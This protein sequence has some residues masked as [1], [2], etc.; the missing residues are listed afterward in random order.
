MLH[1][2]T[3]H[4]RSFSRG[5]PHSIPFDHLDIC[6]FNSTRTP[7]PSCQVD[8][9][10]PPDH[11]HITSSPSSNM[12]HT[13][14][15]VPQSSHPGTHIKTTTLLSFV[16]DHYPIAYS[17]NT[18]QHTQ[19][20]VYSTLDHCSILAQ[21]VRSA[22]PNFRAQTVNTRGTSRRNRTQR[23][24][25]RNALQ[26]QAEQDIIQRD[27][28][29][30]QRLGHVDADHDPGPA[31]WEDID[32]APHAEYEPHISSNAGQ[33]LDEYIAD[34]PSAAHASYHR[35]R[36]YAEKRD[37][38]HKQWVQLEQKTV[39]AYLLCQK[40]TA[41]WTFI[42][43]GIGWDGYTPISCSCVPSDIQS[44][45]VA[46]YDIISRQTP[47]LLP[48]CKCTPDVIRLIHYGFFASSPNKPR[49]A[50]SIRL[51]QFHH[52]L[53]ESAVIS[54]SAFV[55]GLSAF[56]DTRKAEA[57]YARGGKY[58]KRNLRVPFS[59]SVDLYARILV[60]RRK[61]LDVGLQLIRT[62]LW[63]AKCPRCFG[64][65]QSEVKGD[66]CEPCIMVMLDGNFQQRH[67][68][69][70]SKD[71]PDDS[72]YPRDFI[73]PSNISPDATAIAATDLAAAG[74]DPP[75]SDKHKAANDTRGKTTWEKC[76]DTGL[77]ASTCRH[78]IPLMFVNI[79][80]SGEKLYY[81]VTIIRNLLADFPRHKVG[82]LYD[83]GCHLESHVRKRN[84]LLNR[85]SDLRFA[86]SV[87][88]A[89][90]HEWSCQVKYNPCFNS[91]WGL[92]DGEGLE[93][94][95]SFLSPLV[96]TLRV[97][98]R[99]HRLNAIQARADYYTD[100]LNG[101]AA[102]WLL[103]K[104]EHAQEVQDSASRALAELYAQPNR[105]TPGRNYS[106]EFLDVQW[107]QEQAYH[108]N[109][110]QTAQ[111][112]AIELGRLLCLTAEVNQSLTRPMTAAQMLARINTI[113]NLAAELAT[114]RQLMGP[115]IGA[116]LT[117]TQ[118][119]ELAKLWY[120][121]TEL[122]RGFL[123]LAE[124]RQP[125]IRV[126]RPGESTTLGTHGQ[127][128]IMRALRE[129]SGKLKIVL[130]T[131]NTQARAFKTHH[132]RRPAPPLLTYNQLLALQPDDLFWN[133][134]LFTNANDPWAIDP[135]T[136]TGVRHLAYYRR[137]VEEIRRLGWEARRAM[138]WAIEHH[139][140]LLHLIT[141][142]MEGVHTDDLIPDE[143]HPPGPGSFVPI[144]N[145]TLLDS[146]ENPADKIDAAFLV[147]H[148]ALH[149]HLM[150]QLEWNEKIVHVF[151]KTLGPTQHTALLSDWN[152]QVERIQYVIDNRWLSGIPG[153][154][155]FGLIALMNGGDRETEMDSE[156][157][158]LNPDED[159]SDNEDDLEEAYLKDIGRI[160]AATLLED[161]EREA[162]G[163]TDGAG[164]PHEEDGADVGPA[165]G[166]NVQPI[167]V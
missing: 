136:Q 122:R 134:G 154:I 140:R 60:N 43:K 92:T 74:I 46:C 33:G 26:E 90:V 12:L 16:L 144:L 158:E 9:L 49:T 150:L 48:F 8:T 37:E 151:E 107:Q 85:Q 91:W 70:A 58:S 52:H 63:A 129:R 10:R 111:S 125:L 99:Q 76:D 132:P 28:R 34:L 83:L 22:H 86:T 102:H 20:P 30:S 35:A 4:H 138:A 161:L 101:T 163:A 145:H 50:F 143:A 65:K 6:P 152:T 73:P 13:S 45:N 82:I 18:L 157:V 80:K 98:T 148:V 120:T 149:A 114:H 27:I 97:S 89:Y 77:F 25:E 142:I 137:S 135:L 127:Q 103:N 71:N 32:G 159:D 84:L 117:A 53:W 112:Q 23:G 79:Y 96:S 14:C 3:T 15:P 109:S 106:S 5:L 126:T 19:S 69:H 113:N 141:N 105:F 110:N 67:Y 95:W 155:N 21:M 153:A 42:A 59:H 165:A 17:I 121:K 24:W 131:Y 57:S 100:Q 72:Q 36:Q 119:D 118:A 40:K 164:R 39:A 115:Q 166:S 78:D 81:P 64:P 130:E 68:T 1:N 51:V 55:K 167:E 56:L 160:L 123:A 31:V 156:E 88:H 104:L 128:S 133:D 124:E 11:S 38:L 44:R 116:N 7:P 162:G 54:A 93:R 61:I 47:K 41:N 139:L 2:T 66:P 147:L 29:T 94:L 75:C 146:L 87:F 108:L 62:D